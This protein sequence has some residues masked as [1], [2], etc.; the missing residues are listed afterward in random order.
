MKKSAKFYFDDS[1]A[2]SINDNFYVQH[3]DFYNNKTLDSIIKP[4]CVVI[5]IGASC[6]TF[7]N[8]CLMRGAGK[9]ICIEPSPSF[10]I[11]SKTFDDKVVCLNMALSTENID[12]NFYITSNT[13]LSTFDMQDQKK[14]DFG[15]YIKEYKKTTIKCITLKSLLEK[16]NEPVVDLLKFD[17][18]GHE[19]DI[20]DAINEEDLNSINKVLIEF[21]H[22]D[23]EKI[24][25]ITRKLEKSGFY[26]KYLN[27]RYEDEDSRNSLHGV[28]YGLRK[29]V[30]YC[31][32]IATSKSDNFNYEK[33]FSKYKEIIEKSGLSRLNFYNYIIPK[34]VSKNKPLY[35][36]ETGTMWTPVESNMGAFTYIMADLIKNYTGG[37]IYTIDIS[38]VQINACKAITHEYSDV[39][40]YVVSDSVS[41]LKSL[42]ANFVKSLDL[43]Y[44]DSYDLNIFDPHNCMQHHLNEL[45]ALYDNLD[46]KCGIAI[47]DNYLP[48]TWIM[49]NW[50]NSD[51]SIRES[52]RFETEDK[53]VGKGTYCHNFLTERGWKR[54]TEL[55]VVGHNLFYYENQISQ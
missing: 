2:M 37:R 10:E 52:K 46:K 21:H 7:A 32:T 15:N 26:I 31:E 40:E 11:L 35:I 38:D 48:G 29:D 54:L 3:L 51:G 39:I 8:A 13:T 49:W 27:L 44:L 22:N 18:E 23:G 9:V 25:K 30:N 34:L 50:Y 55:D 28:I 4:D 1:I 36:I 53:I 33:F 24:K 5:D 20:F 43:I 19:Y 47:D 6:G 42:E 41:Y 12:K 14:N 17:I 16:I 45:T